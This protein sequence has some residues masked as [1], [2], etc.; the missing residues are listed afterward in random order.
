MKK[1][2][3]VATIAFTIEHYT[4]DPYESL[5][6]EGKCRRRLLSRIIDLD[7]HGDWREAVA[8]DDTIREDD[9]CV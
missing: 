7:E 1:Y 6:L 5:D 3:S 8:F 9:D 2:N 4:K